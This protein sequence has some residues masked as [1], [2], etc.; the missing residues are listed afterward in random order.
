MWNIAT[1]IENNSIKSCQSSIV[2]SIDDT[3]CN[4]CNELMHKIWCM[5]IYQP[6]GMFEFIHQ[7]QCNIKT[8]K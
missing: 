1:K 8:C 6:Y 7:S 5:L 2:N 4:P 3:S